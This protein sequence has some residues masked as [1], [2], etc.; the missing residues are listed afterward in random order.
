[1]SDV[2]VGPRKS[3]L[4]GIDTFKELDEY[5]T[6]LTSVLDY[7]DRFVGHPFF[8]D[9]SENGTFRISKNTHGVNGY[10]LKLLHYGL[11]VACVGYYNLDESDNS[12]VK[13]YD[14]GKT[15]IYAFQDDDHAS[16]FDYQAEGDT[17]ITIPY[18]IDDYN[19]NMYE[20]LEFIHSKEQVNVL[21]CV[22]KL[23][24]SDST[25]KNRQFVI[26]EE[27]HRDYYAILE[28]IKD[29]IFERTVLQSRGF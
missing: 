28:D 14:T 12:W 20:Q 13:C 15:H 29:Y 7:I 1:M 25:R 5:I 4:R 23:T 9:Y 19:E 2:N 16:T 27:H 3:L 6:V 17:F 10:D 11:E 18:S 21:M 8:T 22:A 24:A 26:Y